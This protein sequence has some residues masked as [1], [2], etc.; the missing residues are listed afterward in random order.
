MIH[1][2]RLVLVPVCEY[3]FFSQRAAVRDARTGELRWFPTNSGCTLG[4]GGVFCLR[5]SSLGVEDG[6]TRVVLPSGQTAW[7]EAAIPLRSP[8]VAA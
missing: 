6:L 8:E 3:L 4:P 2:P 7:V 5:T 1:T